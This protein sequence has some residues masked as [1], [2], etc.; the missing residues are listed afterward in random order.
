MLSKIDLKSRMVGNQILK[1]VDSL[2]EIRSACQA[3]L[4][5]PV[6]GKKADNAG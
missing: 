3:E 2:A 5:V 1:V 4:S 6:G